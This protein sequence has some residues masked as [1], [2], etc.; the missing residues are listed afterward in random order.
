MVIHHAY[1]HSAH[2]LKYCAA[3]GQLFLRRWRHGR[4][5]FEK[6]HTPDGDS[7]SQIPVSTH[8]KKDVK[9]NDNFLVGPPGQGTAGGH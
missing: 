8:T 5:I 6:K 7:S 9:W 1:A 4:G 3:I 2:G